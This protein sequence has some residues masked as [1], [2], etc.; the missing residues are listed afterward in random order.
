[1]TDHLWG[2]FFLLVCCAVVIDA[3]DDRTVDTT[4]LDERIETLREDPLHGS[5]GER[6]V[7]DYND[8][9]FTLTIS[10]TGKMNNFSSGAPWNGYGEHI[11]TV[12]IKKGVTSIGDFAF[13][14]CSSLTSVT[15]PSSVSYIGLSAFCNCSSLESIRIPPGLKSIRSKTFSGCESLESITIPPTVSTIGPHAFSQCSNL[16]TLIIQSSSITIAPYS[17]EGCNNLTTI[18]YHGLKT[19][20]CATNSFS[21]QRLPTIR[22]GVPID[23]INSTFCINKNIYFN[24]SFFDDVRQFEN[25]CYEVMIWDNETYEVKKRYNATQWEDRNSEH[26]CIKYVCENSSGPVPRNKCDESEGRVLCMNG[27]CVKEEAIDKRVCVEIEMREMIKSSEVTEAIIL[28]ELEELGISTDGIIVG[29]E[30]DGEG[31]IVRL[32]VYVDDATVAE[33]I[34]GIATDCSV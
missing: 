28:S 23:Y 17:F 16:K 10:G 12:V 21:S 9:S 33:T 5:C 8:A 22:V 1:M 29:W 6:C 24:S 34:A 20:N 25:H 7:Y 15:I 13:E 2:L 30:T 26:D 3:G 19:P 27:E 14:N 4:V 11:K 32:M 31:Y 18:E